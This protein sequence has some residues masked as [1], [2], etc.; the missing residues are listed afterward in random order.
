MNLW[1]T[2]VSKEIV[3]FNGK[4]SKFTCLV[5][6]AQGLPGGFADEE[7]RTTMI[8]PGWEQLFDELQPGQVIEV[9]LRPARE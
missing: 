9:L 3:P 1:V 4:D 5:G 2:K 7:A 6:F 8:I